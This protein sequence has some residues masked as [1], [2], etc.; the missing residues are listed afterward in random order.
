MDSYKELKLKEKINGKIIEQLR[1]SCEGLNLGR[2]NEIIPLSFEE[3]EKKLG[4]KP[5]T[6]HCISSTEVYIED[7]YQDNDR[8]LRHEVS[9]ALLLQKNEVV[10]DS[11]EKL[12]NGL[13]E[14][15]ND[16]LYILSEGFATY[17]E[18]ED[19]ND[20]K[21][22][23]LKAKFNPLKPF[24][25]TLPP[26]IEDK[27]LRNVFNKLFEIRYTGMDFYLMLEKAFGRK[28]TIRF[29]LFNE[30]PY[31]FWPRKIFPITYKEV[32]T[33]FIKAWKTAIA[34][35]KGKKVKELTENDFLTKEDIQSMKS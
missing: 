31:G 34:K 6:N 16:C 2:I 3:A 14:E 7:D 1:E 19:M 18:R 10:K 20:P 4:S 17:M 13:N 35:A 21:I 24:V 30:Q 23:Y 28:K 29:A 27:E 8:V 26:K 5:E 33:L 32:I 11:H 12:K 9:H 22:S 15:L 25:N